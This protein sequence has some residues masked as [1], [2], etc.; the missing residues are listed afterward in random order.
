MEGAAVAQ[1]S[2]ASSGRTN[3]VDQLSE[4]RFLCFLRSLRSQRQQITLIQSYCQETRKCGCKSCA[5]ATQTLLDFY[6]EWNGKRF[7]AP[8][9]CK[10]TSRMSS[11]PLKES[12][13]NRASI[14]FPTLSKLNRLGF[15]LQVSQ[16]AQGLVLLVKEEET[17]GTNSFQNYVSYISVPLISQHFKQR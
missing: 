4:E 7:T 10:M 16:T 15:A 12:T 14:A 3:A 9:L 1:S 2:A 6:I 11:H 8:S 13:S 5:P 17:H